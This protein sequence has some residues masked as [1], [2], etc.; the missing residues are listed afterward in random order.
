MIKKDQKLPPLSYMTP[1]IFKDLKLAV[2]GLLKINP[3]ER[4]E[5]A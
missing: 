4:I 1:G 3:E 5:E 2:D